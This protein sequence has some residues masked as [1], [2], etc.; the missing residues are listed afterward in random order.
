M[1]SDHKEQIL[2]RGL[3]A[4]DSKAIQSIYATH[5]SL[6]QAMVLN[7]NGS[8]DDARDVFQE[9]VVI[10]YEN[11]KKSDFRLTSQ[12]KTYLYAIAK[13]LW[14][15]KLKHHGLFVS[16][17]DLNL[18]EPT[19]SLEEDLEWAKKKDADFVL[20]ESAFQQLGEPCKSL[21]EAFYV[22]KKSMADL[23]EIF[24][25]TNTDN[26]K[27]QKYK[28]LMRLKKLFFAQYSKNTDNE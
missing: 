15:K 17:T 16:N 28:C 3:I 2:L 13:R 6:I 25:Y 11:A 1:N 18:L 5:F 21:L 24:G 27:T 20:M 19:I 8:Y 26:A 14:L 10:L 4:G 22:Q 12:L 9:A 7:N 23:V